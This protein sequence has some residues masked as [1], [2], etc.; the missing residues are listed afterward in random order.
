HKGGTLADLRAALADAGLRV[1]SVIALH[2]WIDT[3]GDAYARALEE[4]RRRMDQAAALGSPIIVASPPRGKVDLDRASAR[5]AD[6]LRLGRQA[7]VQP[8][9]E[10]LGFVDGVNDLATAWK[11]ATGRGEPGTTIVADVFHLLRGGGSVDD[12]LQVSGDRIACFHIND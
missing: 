5:F 1:A 8:S 9:M 7:G 10:F 11:I 12:L 4:C 6:L 3:D 2:D